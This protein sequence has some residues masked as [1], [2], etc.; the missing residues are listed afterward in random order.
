MEEFRSIKNNQNYEVSNFGNVRDVKYKVNKSFSITSKGYKQVCLNGTP[1][2]VHRLVAEAFCEKPDEKC[3][4]VNHMDENKLNNNSSNLEWCTNK[5]N[6]LHS[7]SFNRAA[8]KLS[9]TK[10]IQYDKDGNIIKEWV[11]L[12]AVY[13]ENIKGASIKSSIIRNSFN[14]FYDNSYW[15]KETEVF[16]K[17]RF[18]PTRIILVKGKRTGIEFKGTIGEVSKYLNKSETYI[19]NRLKSATKEDLFYKFKIIE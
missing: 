11:S 5:Q 12:E 8:K 16:D 17:N 7:D 18:K 1:Y 10:I 6:L 2:L 3:N 15:F 19:N 9:K 4:I 14:R 13:K